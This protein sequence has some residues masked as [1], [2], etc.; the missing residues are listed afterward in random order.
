[1]RA[2]FTYHPLHEVAQIF[3]GKTP[4]K[5]DQREIGHPVLKIKDVDDQGVFRGKFES[6]VD[7]S[8]ARDFFSKRVR[9]GDT[10]ILNAAHNA[11]YV[12]SK[13]FYV[14]ERSAGSLATGE[15]LI[16]RPDTR[17]VDPR[18]THHW[19]TD[20]KTHRK[21]KELIKG[22]HLYPKDFA[23]LEIPLPPLDEQ[24]RIAAILDEADALR[25]KRKR[26]LDLLDSLTQ[27]MFRQTFVDQDS[28][29]WPKCSVGSLALNMRTGPFGSQLLHSEFVDEGIAVLGIDNAVSN[30][31]RW[32]E[33]RYIT[34]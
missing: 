31:F 18:F 34:K 2:S 13:Q 20:R 21:I 32:N 9:L 3:N 6:F 10:L 1:V 11:D 24:R 27:S 26:A 5:S 16:V 7:E 15:W 17:K 14:S 19:L 4:S 22:I 33:R 29:S 28:G 8:Y 12:G 30:E 25:R 23:R